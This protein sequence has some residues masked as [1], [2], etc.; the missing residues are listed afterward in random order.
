MTALGASPVKGADRAVVKGHYMEQLLRLS[1]LDFLLMLRVKLPAVDGIQPQ[2]IKFAMVVENEATGVS[3][4]ND[5]P[6]QRCQFSIGLQFK[7]I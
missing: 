4:L 1:M 6:G 7:G 2:S 3:K 5:S